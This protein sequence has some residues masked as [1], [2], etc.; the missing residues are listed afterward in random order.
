MSV[1]L[2]GNSHVEMLLGLGDRL[3]QP[4]VVFSMGSGK[5]ERQPFSEPSPR[6]VKIVEPHYVGRMTKAVGGAEIDDSHQWGFVHVNHNSRL[7]QANTWRRYEPAAVARPD[8]EPVSRGMLE[9]MIRKDQWGVRTFYDQLIQAGVPFFTISAPPPR[10][11]HVAVERGI[12]LE[13]ISYIASVARDLWAEFLGE[14]GVEMI[15]VPEAAK[16][17]EGFLLPEYALV[18]VVNGVKDSHH[19]NRSYGELL[20]DDIRAQFAST[21]SHSS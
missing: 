7:F 6:G 11:D 8:A 12:R 20:V 10:R 5:Y 15:G 17:S 14:R 9:Q 16:D 1:V 2:A 21:G 19:A 3:P 4:N 13:V 18:R